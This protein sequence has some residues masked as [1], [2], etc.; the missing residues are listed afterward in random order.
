MKQ[1]HPTPEI[2]T[3]IT[4]CAGLLTNLSSEV[5]TLRIRLSEDGVWRAIH[6]DERTGLIVFVD[7]GQCQRELLTEVEIT[8]VGERV[9]F[10]KCPDPL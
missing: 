9:A 7:L 5:P 6:P 8:T 4:G 3:K 1:P 10:A 2:G